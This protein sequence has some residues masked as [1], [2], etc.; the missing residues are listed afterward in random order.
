MNVVDLHICQRRT[1]ASSS[2]DHG[3]EVLSRHHE[4]ALSA[5]VGLT[6]QCDQVGLERGLALGV[7]RREALDP[8][9]SST[10]TS[11]QCSGDRYLNAKFRV[12]WSIVFTPLKSS[13]M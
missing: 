12:V 3:L 11:T 10:K 4:A 13:W 6:K 8:G 2:R 1:A 5:Q 9:P 7:K